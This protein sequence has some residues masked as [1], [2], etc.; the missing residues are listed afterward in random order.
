MLNLTSEIVNDVLFRAGEPIDTTSD[1]NSVALDYVNR[2]YRA[3]WIGGGEYVPGMN[4]PWLWLKKDPPGV[5]VLQPAITAGSVAVTQGSSTITFS[6]P[7][8]V[9]VAGTFLH[10]TGFAD[11]FR[12]L[13][14]TAGNANATIDVPY[15]GTS[16]GAASYTDMFLEYALAADLL[17]LVSPMRVQADGVPEIEGCELSALDRDFP[18]VSINS[19]TPDRFALVT[20][21]KIRFNRYGGI[22]PTQQ[23]RI[24]Y[25][26]LQKPADLTGIGSD[27]PL[28]PLEFRQ[29]IADLALFELYTIKSDSRA[30]STGTQGRAGLK[31]MQAYNRNKQQQT[32]RSAGK[33]VTRPALSNRNAR[34]IRTA[35]G[36]IIGL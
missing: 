23:T 16:A 25:D 24:E 32:G 29:V 13:T 4:E 31:S 34:I 17:R 1:F 19:G 36:F 33:L 11:V 22:I 28:V 18:L 3:I 27:A 8:A 10:V 5:L 21:T 20:E 26:Y 15:T 14:H 6:P 30:D 35:S 12:I 9:S 7:P 2:A